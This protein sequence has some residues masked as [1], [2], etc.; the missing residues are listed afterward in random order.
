MTYNK[1][2]LTVDVV[3]LT[4]IERRLHVALMRRDKAPYEGQWALVGGYIHTDEDQDALAAA[5]RT[6]RV[7]LDFTP[8]HLE[9]VCTEAN[10]YR[11]PRGWSASMVYLALHDQEK[12]QHLVATAGLQ[13]FDVEDDGAHLPP[14]MAFDHAQLIRMAV[15]RL[16]AKAAYTTI[17]GHFLPEVF[18]LADMQ[19]TY[20]ALLGLKVNPANFRRKILDM[21]GLAPAEILH[22]TGRPAQGYRLKHDLDYFNRPLG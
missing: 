1:P 3:L 21:A 20:E 12:L 15:Q 13:L 17:G 9:Q 18:S 6:L 19:A 14:D 22:S 8:R 4:L 11:D 2:D 5:L 10:A 16:R 7:K